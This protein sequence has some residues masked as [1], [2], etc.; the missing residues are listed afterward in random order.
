MQSQE[1]LEREVVDAL[2]K[3]LK[4]CDIDTPGPRQPIYQFRAAAI[5]H[6]LAALYHRVY[7]EIESDTD[8]NKKKTSLQL[9]KLY[10]DKAAKLMLSLEQ[11]TEYLTVQMERVALAEYQACSTF[12]F[13]KKI[14]LVL[15]FYRNRDLNFSDGTT[16]NSKLKAYQNGLELILQCKPIMEILC[17]RDNATKPETLDNK[18]E[19]DN[20]ECEKVAEEQKLMDDVEEKLIILLEQRVQFLL[21]SLTKLFLSKSPVHNKKEY[22]ALLLY[23]KFQRKKI[24]I[25]LFFNILFNEISD[26]R[27]LQICTS[28][29]TPELYD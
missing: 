9:C 7:R 29:V 28:N 19:D 1:E 24:Y 23:L 11:S 18:T 8:N 20:A 26:T 15:F 12:F 13:I 2:Q 17:E 27:C 16:F 21:R 14:I 25:L 3:A 6:R 10:Y 4:Y 22:V 5:Q